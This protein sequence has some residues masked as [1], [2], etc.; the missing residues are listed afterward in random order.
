VRSS[1]DNRSKSSLK[2][3]I[4]V[5][6]TVIHT[7]LGRSILSKEAIQSVEFACTNYVNLEYDIESGQRGHRDRLTEDL[8]KKLTGCEASIVVNNNAAAV[9]LCLN[10]LS[11][12]K[13]VIVSRGELVEIGG[14]FRIP[15]VI[16]SSGA[17][18]KEIGT[19][20]RTYIKD[21]QNA[22]N[23]NTA[24]L[25]KIHTSN[26]K[27]E[28][29]TASPS[30]DEVVAVSREK[31]IPV[32]EDLGSGALI[33][34]SKYGLPAEP[35]V[36]NSIKAGVDI[37]TFSGDK[38]LGGPQ[39]GIIV[40]QEKFIA[41][42][43]DNPLMRCVRVGKMTISALDATLRMYINGKEDQIPSIAYLI[44]PVEDIRKVAEDVSSKLREILSGIAEV[45]DQEGTSQV[46]SGSLPVE[47]IPSWHVVLKPIHKS[48]E[49]LSE[50]FRHAE[51]PVIGRINEGCLL[52]DMRTVY[53][54]EIRYL[55]EISNEIR[56]EREI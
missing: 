22:I 31:S 56:K 45:W 39:A 34:L 24:L 20:N 17:I 3:I 35:I 37:V 14:S 32:I 49:K 1:I 38:L 12:G 25:M 47:P 7:N 55:I 18:L 8:I 6:G 11:Q 26:Y 30:I 50:L 27:I 10:T 41:I 23:E 4:N 16:Q 54:D 42:I 52:M 40:G 21:Y 5:T 48:V 29:S 36:K 53:N 15:D 2:K 51:I 46:G 9:L 43:R 33:D 19:T 44:R 13:E 28:G